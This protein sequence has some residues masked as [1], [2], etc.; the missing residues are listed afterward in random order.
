MRAR[1]ATVLLLALAPLAGAASPAHA[2]TG[3][4]IYQASYDSPG[5]DTGSNT[6]L[7]AEY[8]VLK[9]YGTT[10]KTLTGWTLRDKAGHVY[11]F[12]T[13][14][15]AGG[16]YVTIHTGS[17]TN[18]A[19]HRYW[20]SRAYI[21]NNTGDTAYLRGADGTAKDD[22]TWGSTGSSKLC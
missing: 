20:G 13:F 16:A 9:N 5:S 12:G 22:C 1:I 18:T 15:L 8:V 21:W 19:S 3:V 2:A 10:T 14:T 4:N 11:T 6:S 7:N 17:G